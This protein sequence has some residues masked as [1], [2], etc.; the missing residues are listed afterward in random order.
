MLAQILNI[1]FKV[2]Y[3]L[4]IGYNTFMPILDILLAIFA[5][6]L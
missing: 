1:K 5:R 2:F 4:F 3:L 6:P